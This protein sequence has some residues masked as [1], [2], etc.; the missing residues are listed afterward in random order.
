[1]S[2]GAALT[3]HDFNICL[4]AGLLSYLSFHS[5]AF[6]LDNICLSRAQ[7]GTQM[8]LFLGLLAM[9]DLFWN[10][11]MFIFSVLNLVYGNICQCN[12]LFGIIARAWAHLWGVF[13]IIVTLCIAI[14][15]FL[16]LFYPNRVF[17]PDPLAFEIAV[18]FGTLVLAGIATMLLLAGRLHI[19][20]S[21]WCEEKG[22]QLFWNQLP[23]ILAVFTII[24]CIYLAIIIM[25]LLRTKKE[26]IADEKAMRLTFRLTCFVLAYFLIFLGDV[27]NIFYGI[28]YSHNNIDN[29]PYWIQYMKYC[30]IS[31]SGILDM[32]VYGFLNEEFRNRHTL[33]TGMSC[34]SI[35]VLVA[36]C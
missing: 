13:T 12:F 33:L 29:P 28:V 36:H 35:L 11:G 7:S 2:C 24:F 9:G 34:L 32:L 14:Y 20:P 19:T 26:H 1:M 17:F 25:Y 23:I 15:I 10:L 8:K 22:L 16:S 31:S 6:M 21:G 27:I 4:T 30:C 18:T 3:G 5:A